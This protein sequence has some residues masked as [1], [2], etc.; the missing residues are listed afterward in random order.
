MLLVP[1]TLATA[2]YRHRCYEHQ[3]QWILLLGCGA[4]VVFWTLFLAYA[5]NRGLVVGALTYCAGVVAVA[6]FAAAINP[7]PDDD[8]DDGEPPVRP[9]PDGPVNWAKF[10]R[11]F[12]DHVNDRDRQRPRTPVLS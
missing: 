8:D 10:E 5:F 6:A 1:A 12:W 3:L 2:L 11:D 9:D 4:L 7:Y